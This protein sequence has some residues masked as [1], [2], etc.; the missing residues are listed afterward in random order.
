LGGAF[1]A[2]IVIFTALLF[3]VIVL[4]FLAAGSDVAG[5]GGVYG[6]E[7]AGAGGKAGTL[8]FIIAGGGVAAGRDETAGFAVFGAEFAGIGRLTGADIIIVFFR[9]VAAVTAGVAGSTAGHIAG[10]NF[11]NG[12]AFF[13]GAVAFQVFADRAVF[14][15]SFGIAAVV[16]NAVIA[17]ERVFA[18]G[19]GA[20]ITESGVAA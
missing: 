20:V 6:A 15:G 3:V 14:G 11:G 8:F 16:R 18:E 4:V 19:N 13:F 7:V 9:R 12:G 2:D 5:R 1:V 10:N 17:F